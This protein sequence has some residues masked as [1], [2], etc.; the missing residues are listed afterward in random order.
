LL[1]YLIEP[2]NPS[3]L[4]L[5][6][7]RLFSLTALR[8]NSSIQVSANTLDSSDGTSI[9]RSPHRDTETTSLSAS[10]G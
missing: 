3:S 10:K 7:V 4:A 9:G 5:L 2:T 1:L 8:L 6:Q